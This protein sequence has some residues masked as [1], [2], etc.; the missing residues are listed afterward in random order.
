M[1]PTNLSFFIRFFPHETIA[2][3]A[4]LPAALLRGAA[5]RTAAKLMAGS[6]ADLGAVEVVPAGTPCSS[7]DGL[8]VRGNPSMDDEMIDLMVKKW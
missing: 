4:A 8:D 1:F 3:A 7:L 5:A 2:S 6:S